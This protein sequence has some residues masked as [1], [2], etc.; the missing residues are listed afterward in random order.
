[1]NVAPPKVDHFDTQ[2]ANKFFKYAKG[3]R[4]PK[5]QTGWYLDTS[6]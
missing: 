2:E 5:I 4:V 1:M 6:L 3:I